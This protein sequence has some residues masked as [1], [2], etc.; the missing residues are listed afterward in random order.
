MP[1]AHGLDARAAS[2]AAEARFDLT[3]RYVRF[4]ERNARGYV[5]FDFSIGDPRLSVELVMSEAD[6]A[7][8]CITNRVTFLSEDEAH[9]IDSDHQKW[10]YGQPGLSE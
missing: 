7:T 10:R 6:Y 3:R 9:A 1:H 4:R 2:A 5:E 8:F